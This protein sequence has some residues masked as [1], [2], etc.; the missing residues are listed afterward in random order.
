MFFLNDIMLKTN[1]LKYQKTPLLGK[2][3]FLKNHF[4]NVSLRIFTDPGNG[5]ACRRHLAQRYAFIRLNMTQRRKASGSV[6][7]GY[8]IK[9]DKTILNSGSDVLS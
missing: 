6:S 1:T 7:E 5:S 3:K 4:S 2:G 9:F 8:V